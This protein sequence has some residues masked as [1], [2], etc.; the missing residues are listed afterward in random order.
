MILFKSY[1]SILLREKKCTDIKAHEWSEVK[2][3]LADSNSMLFFWR[4]ISALCLYL[5]VKT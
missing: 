3:N 4:H 2:V 5:S 1:A